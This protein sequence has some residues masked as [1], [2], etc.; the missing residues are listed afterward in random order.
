M[1]KVEEKVKHTERDINQGSIVHKL[2]IFNANS[3]RRADGDAMWLFEFEEGLSSEF[4]FVQDSCRFQCTDSQ[5]IFVKTEVQGSRKSKNL[6][7][8][9]TTRA[10]QNIQYLR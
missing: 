1:A 5:K 7:L 10:G 4:S 9:W 2:E 6:N 3:R 8:I